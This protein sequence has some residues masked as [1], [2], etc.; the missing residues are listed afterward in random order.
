MRGGGVYNRFIKKREDL[1]INSY[2]SRIYKF[3]KKDISNEPK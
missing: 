2:K 1:I 3:T